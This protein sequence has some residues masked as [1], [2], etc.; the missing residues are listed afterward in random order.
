[1]TVKEITTQASSLRIFA[2]I[3]T[4]IVRGKANVIVGEAVLYAD[5]TRSTHYM[6]Q[7]TRVSIRY[8]QSDRLPLQ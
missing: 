4:I 8:T 2:C 6:T 3:T 1:M 7:K 5:R